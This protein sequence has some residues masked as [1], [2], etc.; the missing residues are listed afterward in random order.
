MVPFESV[1]L[2]LNIHSCGYGSYTTRGLVV[3]DMETIALDWQSVLDHTN[4]GSN[5]E[6]VCKLTEWWAEIYFVF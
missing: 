2:P 6:A 1:Y 5:G 4:E 3:K